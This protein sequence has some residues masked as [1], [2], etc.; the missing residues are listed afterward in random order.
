VPVRAAVEA[1]TRG[2]WAAAGLGGSGAGELRVGAPAHLAVWEI[3]EDETL[4][5]A[6]GP[7]P[8]AFGT[9]WRAYGTDRRDPVLPALA[10]DDPLPRCLRTVRAGVVLHD[11][12]G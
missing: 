8:S 6:D 11:T 10:D 9:A 2:G 12:L 5:R 7:A 3:G 1:A 4:D